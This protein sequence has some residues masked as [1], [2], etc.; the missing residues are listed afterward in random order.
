MTLPAHPFDD[1]KLREAAKLGFTA[2]YLPTRP[3]AAN[4]LEIHPVADLAA[5]M[6]KCFGTI[7]R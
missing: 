7:E 4:E 2:A 1:D 5:F 3:A 6:E